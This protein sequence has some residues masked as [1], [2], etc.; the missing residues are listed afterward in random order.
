MCSDVGVLTCVFVKHSNDVKSSDSSSINASFPRLSVIICSY[1]FFSF[2]YCIFSL[3]ILH[4]ILLLFFATVVKKSII[5]TIKKT[6]Q[7]VK[8]KKKLS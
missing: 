2:I 7:Q 3:F 8:N 6:C 1:V 5:I 4:F